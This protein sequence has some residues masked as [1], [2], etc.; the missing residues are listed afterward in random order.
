VTWQDGQCW[1]SR[2][3]RWEAVEDQFAGLSPKHRDRKNRP[4]EKAAISISPQPP[5]DPETTPG[6]H[7]ES[8]IAA[9]TYWDRGQPQRPSCISDG[10]LSAFEIGAN[11]REILDLCAAANVGIAQALQLI[12]ARVLPSAVRAALPVQQT[13]MRDSTSMPQLRIEAA[14]WDEIFARISS[15][16]GLPRQK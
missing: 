13:I 10:D 6:S 4:T 9:E 1:N 14:D 11:S 7:A 2:E 5:T 3:R 8:A 12:D 15:E 16:A